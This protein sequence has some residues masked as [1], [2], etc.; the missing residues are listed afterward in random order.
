MYYLLKKVIF[1]Y[2][3]FLRKKI[4]RTCIY[5]ISCSEYALRTLEE[6]RGLFHSISL[7]YN[8]IRGCKVVSVEI[9]RRNDWHVINGNNQKILP[10]ELST[11]AHEEY[12]N[13]SQARFNESNEARLILNENFLSPPTN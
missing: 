10:P 5:K 13:L 1:F 8:R 7:I 9:S 3:R 4:N 6:R 11:D 2:R 12:G